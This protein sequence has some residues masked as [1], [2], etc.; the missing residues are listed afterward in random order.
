MFFSNY[1]K[2]IVSINI[3]NNTNTNV[4]GGHIQY[5]KIIYSTQKLRNSPDTVRANYLILNLVSI[6]LLKFHLD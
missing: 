3:Y 6:Y 1:V 5:P 2:S 4:V